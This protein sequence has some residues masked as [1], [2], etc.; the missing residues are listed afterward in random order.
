[1][2]CVIQGGGLF[3]LHAVLCVFSVFYVCL[4]CL[5]CTDVFS[6]VLVRVGRVSCRFVGGVLLEYRVY[7]YDSCFVLL[8]DVS[9]GTGFLF[10]LVRGWGFAC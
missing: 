2:V 1:M 7:Y 8:G 4:S 9:W 6:V 5:M 3:V 10:Q